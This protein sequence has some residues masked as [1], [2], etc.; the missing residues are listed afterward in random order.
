M[1]FRSVRALGL[2]EQALATPL[3]VAGGTAVI[4]GRRFTDAYQWRWPRHVA[5]AVRSGLIVGY[6]GEGG[7]FTFGPRLT[8][9][10]A[11][12]AT[13]VVRALDTLAAR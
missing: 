3:S 8:A 9:T 6:P 4:A 5:E 7:S 13:L 1:L 11:E 10:R 2:E 12:A